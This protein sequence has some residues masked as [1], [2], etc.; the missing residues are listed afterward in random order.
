M[1]IIPVLDILDKQV[2]HGIGGNRKAYQPLSKSVITSSS[3]PVDVIH[4]FQE[5]LG[6]NWFYIADLNRIQVMKNLSSKNDLK[7]ASQEVKTKLSVNQSVIKQLKQSDSYLMLDGG[8]HSLEDAM[9]LQK[10]NVDQIILGTE[11]LHSPHMLKSIVNVLDAEE[12]IL[13]IDLYDGK[14]L[15]SNTALQDSTALALAKQ[16]EQLGLKAII[17]LE[18]KKVGSRSGPLHPGLL[19]IARTITKIPVFGGGGVRNKADLEK[20]QKNGIDG[21]LVATAFHNG[22]LSVTDLRA[23]SS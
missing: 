12:L 3:H 11:T 2:V 21:V 18:L 23:F 15:T 9:E 22:T 5:K 16:A 10:Y 7:E 17:V 20:L 19:K 8:C 6:L 14:L 4:A 1:H 13:S